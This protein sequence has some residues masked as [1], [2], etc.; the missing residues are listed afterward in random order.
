MRS[1]FAE[2][3]R[4]AILTLLS[5]AN[6]VEVPDL[7][8][9]FAVSEDSV[10]R[11]L[12]ALAAAGFLQKTHGGAV[13]LDIRSLD[14]Q[15]RTEVQATAKTQIGAAAA[16]LVSPREALILDGGLTVLELAKSLT[17]RPLSVLTNSLDV[18]RQ[19]DRDDQVSLTVTGGQWNPGD[20]F[21]GGEHAL[22][23][24]AAHRADWV[25]L[26][27]CALHPE[28]G[29]TARHAAD[30]SMKRAML[31][32]GL[33]PVLLVDHSKFGQVAPHFVG[34]LTALHA[35]VTDRTTKWLTKAGPRII[36][37]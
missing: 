34:P 14:W 25:F 9:R 19:L 15:A 13:A 6:R 7:A 29:M 27:A 35:V 16:A 28:A 37:A 4:K 26:G 11:D 23:T 10:R 18:A 21:L 2:E 30:A 33:R 12:R 24:L 20:R 17:V 5:G 1:V 8:K 22:A 32:A 36:V 3:R 31:R